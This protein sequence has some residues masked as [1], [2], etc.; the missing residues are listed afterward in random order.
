MALPISSWDKCCC[1]SVLNAEIE[2]LD[3]NLQSMVRMGAA[4][5]AG[6]RWSQLSN[7]KAPSRAEPLKMDGRQ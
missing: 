4:M 1:V 6:P 5:A 2:T 7:Q 3:A